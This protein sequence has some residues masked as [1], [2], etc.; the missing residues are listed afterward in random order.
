MNMKKKI[1]GQTVC[2]YFVD[3]CC[4]YKIDKHLHLLETIN[5]RFVFFV[6]DIFFLLKTTHNMHS[7]Y[8]K[9]LFHCSI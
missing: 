8:T 6:Y 3:S 2:A 1:V 5:I 9:C 4:L 7:I